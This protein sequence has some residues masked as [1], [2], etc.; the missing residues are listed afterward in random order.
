MKPTNRGKS[1]S[2]H[3]VKRPPAVEVI[4]D[5]A[6]GPGLRFRCLN[7]RLYGKIQNEAGFAVNRA[8]HLTS[9]QPEEV[10]VMP[11]EREGR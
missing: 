8:G 10:S 6:T 1:F 3:G 9:T 4:T 7:N 2:G 11:D 5:D